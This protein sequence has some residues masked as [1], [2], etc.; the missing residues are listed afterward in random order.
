MPDLDIHVK[1]PEE[2]AN[3]LKDVA[4]AR[5]RTLSNEIVY[6]LSLGVKWEQRVQKLERQVQFVPLTLHGLPPTMKVGKLRE[7]KARGAKSGQPARGKQR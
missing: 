5:V 2:L 4:Q 6:L 7:G 3:K 1:I